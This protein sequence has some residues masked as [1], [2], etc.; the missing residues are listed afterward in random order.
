MH[1]TPPHDLYVE[2]LLL[3]SS[4][5]VAT[6]VDTDTN[7]DLDLHTP[8]GAVSP[9]GHA[10][11]AVWLEIWAAAL[12]ASELRVCCI[13]SAPSS[14]QHARVARFRIILVSSVGTKVSARSLLLARTPSTYESTENWQVARAP[15]PP[16]AM[17]GPRARSLRPIII[18][19]S[20]PSNLLPPVTPVHESSS[21]NEK[22]TKTDPSFS[23]M[24]VTPTGLP[25]NTV[26][27]DIHPVFHRFFEV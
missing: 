13:H 15:T 14:H 1:G 5:D 25:P 18:P 6:A 12:A 22:G 23:T 3:S 10:Q 4:S 7:M 11:I 19:L 8:P 2:V 20:F 26:K 16:M 27:V 24:T 17:A 21:S 9:H